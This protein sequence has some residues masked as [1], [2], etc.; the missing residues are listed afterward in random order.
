MTADRS[1]QNLTETAAPFLGRMALAESGEALARE[2]AS[3]EAQLMY[4]ADRDREA[5]LSVLRLASPT[6]RE[7]I[8]TELT[9][10]LENMRRLA[11][12][13]HERLQA[14]ANRR[15]AELGLPRPVQPIEA[16]DTMSPEAK[17]L[18]VKRKRFG[19]VT[20]D[21]LPVEQR[22]GYPGFGDNPAPLTLL[23][24]CDG[25]RTV[26]EVAR[27]VQLEQGPLKFDF[28]GYFQFLAKHGYVELTT[29]SQ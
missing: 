3:G 25:K 27:L 4:E 24:W 2:L 11:S 7:S 22:E 14:A 23:S 15:A 19:P 1:N 16:P 8:R 21:D 28:V 12:E 18:V 9:P 17:Q 6:K 29:A 20:L 26:A 13:Q 5:L 10:Q